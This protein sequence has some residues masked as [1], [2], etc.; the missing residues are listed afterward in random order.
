[1]SVFITSAK[2]LNLRL[3]ITSERL[4]NERPVW[5]YKTELL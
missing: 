1:M 4:L 5:L 2:I 3:T